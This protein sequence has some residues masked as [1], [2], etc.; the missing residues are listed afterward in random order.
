MRR[1][2]RVTPTVRFCASSSRCICR[3]CSPAMRFSSSVKSSVSSSCAISFS[4]SCSSTCRSSVSWI[5][6]S[7]IEMKD[8]LLSSEPQMSPCSA[9]SLLMSRSCCGPILRAISKRSTGRW[10]DRGSANASSSSSTTSCLAFSMCVASNS[11]IGS[12]GIMRRRHVSSSLSSS[13]ASR[14]SIS[15]ASRFQIFCSPYTTRSSEPSFAA[16]AMRRSSMV[17][18]A[19]LISC[20]FSST[21]TSNLSGLFAACTSSR[22]YRLMCSYSSW[23]RSASGSCPLISSCTWSYHWRD[24]S[25]AA[26]HPIFFPS[27]SLARRSSFSAAATVSA[28]HCSARASDQPSS[29][30]WSASI[31]NCTVLLESD[32]NTPPTSSIS[33]S[34]LNSSFRSSTVRSSKK[35]GRGPKLLPNCSVT[36]SMSNRPISAASSSMS[37]PP[38]GP[39]ALGG[40]AR[41]GAGAQG[42]PPR[43]GRDTRALRG[44]RASAAGGRAPRRWATAGAITE[45]GERGGGGFDG[46]RRRGSGNRAGCSWPLVWRR[47]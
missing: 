1:I 23:D 11:C 32:L 34:P 35:S 41:N 5:T 24:S 27:T 15:A 4:A 44:V 40:S 43:P 7:T 13:G 19:G 30:S 17:S 8:S 39:L 26:S 31:G 14:R 28:C 3:T 22:M 46:R 36:A 2:S 33:I 16:S 10:R 38:F 45:P 18:S 29:L 42:R 21:S 6:S 47:R 12:S 20:T 25:V 37:R 9:S